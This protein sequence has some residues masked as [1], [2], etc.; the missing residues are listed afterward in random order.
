MKFKNLVGQIKLLPGMK[1]LKMMSVRKKIEL[2]ISLAK[3]EKKS[4]LVNLGCG[5]RYHLDW[6]NIDF[7]GD[8]KI[9]YPWDFRRGLPLPSDS[10]DAIYSSHVLEHLSRNEAHYFLEE[11][12][13][14]IKRGGVLR[15]ALPDLEGIVRSYIKCLDEVRQN[16]PES[17]GRYEWSLI[18]LLDQMTRHSSGGEMLKHWQQTTVPAESYIIERVGSEYQS[19]RSAKSWNYAKVKKHRNPVTWLQAI[20]VGRFRL[21]G[22]IHQ[23]MYD[24]FSLAKLL[25]DV[26]FNE[27]KIC[28]PADSRISNFSTYHLDAND[29]GVPHKPDSFYIEAYLLP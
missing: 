22:E 28:G 26:G 29:N 24:S 15:L 12:L 1:L 2:K 21:G 10:C 7:N 3:Q 16:L 6:I 4:I 5:T 17:I 20:L 14:S 25:R 13:R 19:F 23:W 18:E 9:V 11:C 27:I 8:G